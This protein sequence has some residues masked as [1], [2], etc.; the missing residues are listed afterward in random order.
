MRQPSNALIHILKR[1]S[2]AVQSGKYNVASRNA[3]DFIKLSYHLE[4][5][6]DLF[7]GE[8]LES[9]YTQISIELGTHEI[10]K[11][12]KSTL[13]KVMVKCLDDLIKAYTS[14]GPVYEALVN[15]RYSATAFQYNTQVEYDFKPSRP[16][17]GGL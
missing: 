12:A 9:V 1:I 11:E 7:M 16:L 14:D 5:A 17:A 10:S 4:L 2:Q 15:M 8:V 13:D 6:N 3:A